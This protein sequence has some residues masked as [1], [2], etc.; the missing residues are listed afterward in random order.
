MS[1]KTILVQMLHKAS[2]FEVL[3]KKLVLVVQKKFFEYLVREFQTDQLRTANNSDS[4]HFH[5]YDLV[6]QGSELQVILDERRS[7]SVVG[8]ERMLNFGRNSEILE[9]D[10]IN[11]ISA[12]MPYAQRIEL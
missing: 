4:V 5:M 1:A 7:T 8:V 2:S 12:K 9:Q 3:G 6:L 11:R 10:V